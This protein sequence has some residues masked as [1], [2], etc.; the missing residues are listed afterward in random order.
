M[1]FAIRMLFAVSPIRAEKRIISMN[2]KKKILIGYG[3]A[4]TLMGLVATWAIINL[5]SL[6]KTTDAILRDYYQSILAVENMVDALGRQDSGILLVLMGD[7]EKGIAQYRENDALFLEWLGRSRDS[8]AVAGEREVIHAIELEY[9]EYAR[10]INEVYS[11][12]GKRGVSQPFTLNTYKE[13]ILPVFSRVKATCL[14]LR[15]MNEKTMYSDSEK[16]R[17]VAR[18]AIWSTVFVASVASFIA[19][20]FSL[21]FAERLVLPLRRFVEA[22]KKI[23]AGEFS[24][25]LSVETRDEL[26]QLAVEFNRM[27]AELRRYHMMN[28]DRIVAEKNKGEAILASIEDGLVVFDTDRK[29]TGIN[30]AGCQILNVDFSEKEVLHCEQILPMNSICEIVAETIRTGTQPD[31]PDDRRIITLKN[32]ESA[33]Y[34]L[35]SATAIGQRDHSLSCVVLLLKDITQLREVERLKSEFV[36]AASHEL[37]TPLTSLGMGIDLLIEHAVQYLPEREKELL[38]AA[39]DEVHR[40]KSMVHDLLDL[41]KIETGRIDLEFEKIPVATLFEHARDIFK[42]QVS[43]KHINLTIDDTEFMPLV[44]A[45][46]NKIV[47]VLSNLISNALRYVDEGGHIRLSA[48]RKGAEL[49][50]AVADDGSGIPPEYQSLIFQKFV[51]VNRQESGRTG[52]GLAI[53][54]EIV[55]AHGGTIRVESNPGKGSTFTFTLP[56]VS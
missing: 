29:V 50:L 49:N 30:P 13:S 28:V 46:T 19:L 1:S 5:W 41:S 2:L 22:A 17:Q 54:R 38:H 24:V 9:G 39:H 3:F 10:K 15:T 52:L 12:E 25:Q 42:G 31:I 20:F 56:V 43:M 34:Y 21:V 33:R 36:M 51:R 53:C 32:G 6:G 8:I 16:A 11:F 55:R 45:D 47:W 26:G 35:F 7:I 18:R 23:S 48:E 4:F 27:T 40:M 37:R 14:E 44:R